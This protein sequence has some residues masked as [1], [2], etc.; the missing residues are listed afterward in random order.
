MCSF[1]FFNLK[2]RIKRLFL[3][4]GRQTK[5]CAVFELC[6]IT[7]DILWEVVVDPNQNNS[8][9]TFS[10]HILLMTIFCTH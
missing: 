9:S 5:E 6:K 8:V 2:D 7:F 10:F 3:W 1:E 4:G